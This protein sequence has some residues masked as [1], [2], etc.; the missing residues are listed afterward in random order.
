MRLE[1]HL[2]ILTK[3]KGDP[4]DIE[5][6]LR[7]FEDAEDETVYGDIKPKISENV[8]TRENPDDPLPQQSVKLPSPIKSSTL[9]KQ[10]A[11]IDQAYCDTEERLDVSWIKELSSKQRTTKGGRNKLAVDTSIREIN[12]VFGVTTLFRGS[13]RVASVHVTV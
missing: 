13:S 10:T 9:C 8:E 3:G 1:A 5:S 6:R 11:Q 12:T 2:D 4:E 7:D